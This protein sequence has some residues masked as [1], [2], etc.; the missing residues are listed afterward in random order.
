MDVEDIIV[1]NVYR[2]GECEMLIHMVGSIRFLVIFYS[3]LPP[4]AILYSFQ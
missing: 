1:N 4:A 2:D 3:I